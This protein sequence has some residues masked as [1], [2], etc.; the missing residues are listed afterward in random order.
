MNVAIDQL[1]MNSKLYPYILSLVLVCFA[2]ATIPMSSYANR[3]AP[4]INDNNMIHRIALGSESSPGSDS[5]S[6][7][8]LASA[9]NSSG[10]SEL[11]STQSGG[12]IFSSLMTDVNGTYAN[13]DIGFQIDL[14][15]DWK[16]QEMKFLVNT[17]LVSPEGINFTD[18]K[19]PKT[20]MTIIGIN[21]ET[22]NKITN[23]T[24][25]PV[26]SGNPLDTNAPLGN[27]VPCKDEVSPSFVT[28]NGIRAEQRSQECTVEGLNGKAKSYAFATADN[29]IIVVGLFSNSTSEY[30]QYLPLFD[31]SVKTIKISKPSDIATSDIYK[32]YKEQE[33]ELLSQSNQTSG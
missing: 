17:V 12:S 19:Q 6:P 21:Q 16:G 15:K 13:P 27:T 8:E 10:L 4:Q 1:N 7:S 23:I 5:F 28:I 11:G 24:K 33:L 30:N 14:P 20:F 25:S 3:E 18:F 31:Q 32:K 29:S 26:S 2:A 9:F 22:L